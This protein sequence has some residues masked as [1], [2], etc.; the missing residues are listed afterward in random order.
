VEL[1]V[2]EKVADVVPVTA[3]WSW[4][5]DQQAH[6]FTPYADEA[7]QAI[8][9]VFLQYLAAPNQENRYV[10]FRSG[11]LTLQI[12]FKTMLQHKVETPHL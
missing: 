6:I 9:R 12:D 7:S 1:A 10:Q 11:P 8:E 3:R 2:P 5:S 4:E